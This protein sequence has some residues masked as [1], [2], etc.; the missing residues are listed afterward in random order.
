VALNIICLA[1]DLFC[2]YAN[3][4]VMDDCSRYQFILV[5]ANVTVLVMQVICVLTVALLYAL[6]IHKHKLTQ[7]DGASSSSSSKAAAE[8]TTS[9]TLLEKDK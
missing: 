6:A 1:F 9:S 7:R 2:R 4:C 5:I 8:K 3:I